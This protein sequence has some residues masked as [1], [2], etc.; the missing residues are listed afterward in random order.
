L[1]SLQQSRVIVTDTAHC[2]ESTGLCRHEP[3]KDVHGLSTQTEKAENVKENKNSSSTEGTLTELA[4][5]VS[6]QQNSEEPATVETQNCSL[7]EK[8]ACVTEVLKEARNEQN[9][10]QET[11]LTHMTFKPEPVPEFVVNMA[12]SKLNSI[13]NEHAGNTDSQV[14]QTETSMCTVGDQECVIE[15]QTRSTETEE[16]SKVKLVAT[17]TV[18]ESSIKLNSQEYSPKSI[19]N[20]QVPALIINPTTLTDNQELSENKN[21][22]VATVNVANSANHVS[23]NGVVKVAGAETKKGKVS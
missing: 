22:P 2:S 15:S 21:I 8:V 1:E 5:N 11:S 13:S 7:D 16:E 18:N 6:S 3:K 14:S 20:G 9:S 12:E 4:L 19:V 23:R 17:S 10:V